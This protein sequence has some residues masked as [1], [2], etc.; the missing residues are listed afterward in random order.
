MASPFGGSRLELKPPERGIFPLDHDSEC[1]PFVKNFLQC[2][3]ENNNDHF[4]CREFSKA[5]LNCR[6]EK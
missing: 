4:Y 1:K 2:L 6:M 5:Y 3:K